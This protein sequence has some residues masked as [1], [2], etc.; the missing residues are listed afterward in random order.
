MSS[1][2]LAKLQASLWGI[3]ETLDT[4]E[5]SVR[6]LYGLVIK[7][8]RASMVVPPPEKKA[9]P[10]PKPP[11]PSIAKELP[12]EE[13]TSLYQTLKKRMEETQETHTT[14][15][16]PKKPVVKKVTPAS[17]GLPT[18]LSVPVNEMEID[19]QFEKDFAAAEQSVR[20]KAAGIVKPAAPKQRKRRDGGFVLANATPEQLD[21]FHNTPQ[22]HQVRDRSNEPPQSHKLKGAERE[23]AEAESKGPTLLIGPEIDGGIQEFG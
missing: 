9:A 18:S 4:N 21:R 6:Q 5:C 7:A 2:A 16:A 19:E 13:S 3:L 8:L 11:K 12:S 10:E 14:A 17:K 15:P 1:D 23:K 22:P 20:D